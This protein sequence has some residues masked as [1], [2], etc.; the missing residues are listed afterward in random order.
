MTQARK[1]IC[2]LGGGFG[3]LYTAL[4]L[5]ELPWEEAEQPQITLV[6]QNEHFLFSPLLYELLTGELQAWEIAPPFT[7]ILANTK[8]SY[9]QAKVNNVDVEKQRVELDD[10]TP[11]NYDQLVIATGGETPTEIVKG[12]S[13]YAIPFRHLTDAYT[14][15][16][17]LRELDQSKADYLRIA[18]VGGGY[19]GVEIACKLADRLGD[20]GRIRIIERGDVI[21][22]NSPEF[23]RQAARK[24]LESKQ[25]WVDLETEV[26][27]INQSS[28]SLLYKGKTD[29]IPVDLV[30]WTVGIQV[31]ELIAKLPLPKSDRQFLSTNSFLQ[32]VDHPQIYALGDI[33]DCKDAQ[34]KQV[35]KTAQV[36]IQ[37]AD[38]CA[39]NIW[40]RETGR[41]CLPFRYQ[42]LGEMMTLGQDNATL[43]SMG[44]KLE[45]EAA[46]LI[47]R[48]VYLYR[49]PGKKQQLTVGFNWLT[50]PLL[51]LLAN[52]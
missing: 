36:A 18:I 11:L 35:P 9:K 31:P 2:I 14:L 26:Q 28:I 29:T 8:I 21:L 51:D 42:P 23:N 37:Q 34:G 40:A 13:A 24:A 4:R 17:K 19:S 20:R 46:H 32:V 50:Q 15:G 33:S 48:L 30:I 6:D 1:Q 22:R 10:D 49:M 39:W 38:Y 16:H 3:G 12:A 27:E 25:I 47:R 41:P 45:G 43:T 52:Y 44:L 5:N 7:E